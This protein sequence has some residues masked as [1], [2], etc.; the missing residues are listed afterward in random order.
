[1]NVRE[2]NKQFNIEVIAR[3]RET[4]LSRP[5]T[6]LSFLAGEAAN[7]AGRYNVTAGLSTGLQLTVA[8]SWAA[9]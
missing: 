5:P 4:R 1:L 6:R 8:S 7:H 2:T 3:D 9:T